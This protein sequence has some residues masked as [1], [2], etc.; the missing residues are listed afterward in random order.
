MEINKLFVANAHQ[1]SKKMEIMTEEMHQ[2][3]KRMEEMTACT[4]ILAEKTEKQTTSMHIVTLVTLVFLPG[5][6]VAV[7]YGLPSFRKYAEV[8][9]ASQTFFSSGAFQWDQNNPESSQMPYWKPGFFALFA[10]IC[11]PMTGGIILLWYLSYEWARWRR[12]REEQK[13]SSGLGDLERQ[14]FADQKVEVTNGG[15]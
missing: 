2:S 14:Q 3:T 4:K 15:A 1:S 5:T 8:L 13:S 7:R 12:E 6:F 9:T 11:F 10:E